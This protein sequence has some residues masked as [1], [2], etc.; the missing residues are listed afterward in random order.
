MRG[1][2]CR[3]LDRSGRVEVRRT[4]FAPRQASLL[5]PDRRRFAQAATTFRPT[6]TTSAPQ[7]DP[8]SSF[9]AK[10]SPAYQY[11]STAQRLTDGEIRG[12]DASAP[13]LLEAEQIYDSHEA[14]IEERRL[15]ARARLYGIHSA[16]QLAFE[17][18]IEDKQPV[19]TYMLDGGR[20]TRND[21]DLWVFLLGVT[22]KRH[23]AGGVRKL[24]V[25][26]SRRGPPLQLTSNNANARDMVDFFI[27]AATVRKDRHGGR[28]DRYAALKEVCQ[29]CAVN[30][31]VDDIL[32]VGVVGIGLLRLRPP[33]ATT[34][35][36]YLK[37]RGCYNGLDDLMQV[38]RGVC[39]TNNP[40][41]LIQCN[42]LFNKMAPD[43]KIYHETVSYL[44][45][46][47]HSDAALKW[48][49]YR[50]AQGDLPQTLDILRPFIAHHVVHRTDMTKF[51]DELES[52]GV[53]YYSQIQ[54]MYWQAMQTFGAKP[55]NQ[56]EVLEFLAAAKVTSSLKDETIARALA[57]STLSF[58]FVLNSLGFL[59]VSEIGPLAVRQVVLGASDLAELQTRFRE[60]RDRGI[61]MGSHPFVSIIRTLFYQQYF[62][63]LKRI[64][65]TDMHH[66]EFTRRHLQSDLL[67]TCIR[68]RDSE[69]VTR[70]L[71]ILQ[72]SNMLMTSPAESLNTLLEN[73]ISG[74]DWNTVLDL[75]SSLQQTGFR[76][77]GTVLQRLVY[78]C[79]EPADEQSSP[80]PASFDIIGFAI[81]ICQLAVTSGSHLPI[82]R[83]RTLIL[84]LSRHSR[85]KEIHV[86]L[87]WLLKTFGQ[88]DVTYHLGI[89]WL[90]SPKF[91]KALIAW[92]FSYTAWRPF[93]LA[94]PFN[95]KA[96][97]HHPHID[98]SNA[99]WLRGTRLLL[100]LKAHPKFANI[101][102]DYDALEAEYLRRVRVLYEMPMLNR[103][104][105][106]RKWAKLRGFDARQMVEHWLEVWQRTEGHGRTRADDFLGVT[107][108]GAHA[109]SPF[110][111]PMNQRVRERWIRWARQRSLL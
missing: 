77:K 39:D 60:L 71:L 50:L 33:M 95:P 66:D 86:L 46:H 85:I 89:E 26:L 68:N 92:D 43:E 98:S 100:E 73:A 45:K 18:N 22:W 3:L 17:L 20:D 28:K 93:L 52:V 101:H 23:H 48:H 38:F 44:W 53:D 103:L 40:Q 6:W 55:T 88:S 102:I 4:T 30:R 72:S 24:W 111:R 41:A 2:C 13:V 51:L 35:A 27:Y 82:T 78:K 9:G 59:G 7:R 12:S 90:F 62:D 63:L 21:L 37:D 105:A 16:E 104:T 97:G 31:Y 109:Q 49:S 84:A 107:H 58:N 19:G 64:A 5:S 1:Q 106:N 61:D 79:V 36:M 47:L 10:G 69:G 54:S 67:S 42:E 57:T 25:A 29:H 14:L 99:P 108:F 76:V 110:W 70:T 91:Q 83:W 81:G 80:S 94:D 87:R 32:F 56:R 8:R 65:S 74:S 96:S 11:S 15:L 34:I 75:V